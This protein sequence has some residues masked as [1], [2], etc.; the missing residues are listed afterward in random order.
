[1]QTWKKLIFRLEKY[2]QIHIVQKQMRVAKILTF[3]IIS[4]FLWM[5]K[6]CKK[7][8]GKLH[9]E[10]ANPTELQLDGVGAHL[11]RSIIWEM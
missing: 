3:S 8:V 1:M 5:D 11:M 6:N 10:L 2:P 4:D 9:S 7:I